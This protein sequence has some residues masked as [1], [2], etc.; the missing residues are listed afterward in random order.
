MALLTQRGP[1]VADRPH[2]KFPKERDFQVALNARVER[3]LRFTHQSAQD[4]PAMYV[5]TAIVLAWLVLSYLLLVFWAP[6]WWVSL[7]ATVSLALAMSAA[8]FNVQHDGAHGAYSR[9]SRVNR[10]MALTLDLLGGSSYVWA[11]KHNT[12]HHT[13]TNITGEDEDINVG[14]LARLSPQQRWH[15]WHRAQWWYVWVLYAG[16]AI[17]WQMYDDLRDVVRGRVGRH[18]FARPTGWNL[19][20]F[21][22]G[23]TVS[24]GLA[25][26]L[27]SLFHPFGMVLL[28][29][30]LAFAIH[31]VCLSIVF[32]MAHVVEGAAFP[33][34][35]GATGR[36]ERSWAAHQV[37]T[38][39][40]FARGSRILSWLLGGL[41]YQIEHHLFPRICHV[42]YPR[43]AR[44]VEHV[45][46]RF[47]V[48]Y[49]AHGS[50]SAGLAAHVRW[51]WEMG[52]RPSGGDVSR[53]ASGWDRAFSSVAAGGIGGTGRLAAGRPSVS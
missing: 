37:E 23:K 34:S 30:A 36:M 22:G 7:P 17:K 41:N 39:V 3:Y 8:G 11:H 50:F 44:L 49:R 20:V 33:E 2:P 42:H 1:S 16:L 12:V 4:Q 35:D 25:F 38:T 14:R 40:D 9:R 19:A 10:L 45:A 21:M 31:G 32:Q 15:W 29:Y 43:I 28:F 51:L 47:G 53:A 27:P 26:G 6:A 48:R 24:M 13:Y 18:R 46:A 52:W 5:K